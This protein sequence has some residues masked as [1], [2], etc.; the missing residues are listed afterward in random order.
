M[1]TISVIIPVYNVEKY[2]QECLDSVTNQTLKDIEIICINDGSTDGSLKILEDYASKDNRIIIINQENFGPAIARNNG[3]NIAKGDFISFI[4]SDDYFESND[5]YE[6]LYN[7][8][9]K[10]SADAVKGIYRYGPTYCTNYEINKKIQENK[11]YFFVEYTSA[12]FKRDIIEKYY[13]R[14]PDIRDMEDPIFTFNFALKAKTII[15]TNSSAI[16]IR[17]RE[18][19]ITSVIPDKNQINTKIQGLKVII[20][21]AKDL[22]P[23]EYAYITAYW[24]GNIWNEIRRNKNLPIII[25]TYK[26]MRNIYE[27]LENTKE[28]ANNI[29]NLNLM[30]AYILYC[31]PVWKKFFM[32]II[33]IIILF[34]QK[35][36][37]IK[38]EYFSNQKYKVI[39]VL[40][41]K[42]KIKRI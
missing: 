1:P 37:S 5:F 25:Q 20:N 35:I 4:D 8:A 21:N 23:E 24:F 42:I 7:I 36:F 15:V 2:L 6:N 9:I 38:N 26:S 34:L 12:I 13:L 28:V 16:I 30:E 41:I 39:T 40:G 17:K 19:S 33:R 22:Q 18:G 27:S 31:V 32:I 11:N 29:K 10:K 3:L 14:F